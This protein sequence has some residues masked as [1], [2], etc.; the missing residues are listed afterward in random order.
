MAK[1]YGKIGF[2]TTTETT[3]GVWTKSFVEREYCGDI[4]KNVR[5]NSHGESTNDDVV[6][7][8]TFSLISDPYAISHCNEMKYLEWEGIRWKIE[9]ADIEYPRILLTLGGE[10]NGRQTTTVT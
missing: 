8:N 5:R 2:R 7:Q 4:L 6:I 1:F 10:Y 3:P 9:S